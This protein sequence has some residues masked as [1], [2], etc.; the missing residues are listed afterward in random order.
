MTLGFQ[1]AD[2]GLDG[3][4]SS[5]FASDD[6]EDAALLSRDEDAA[7]VLR[8]MTAV[9][10]VDIVRLGGPLESALNGAVPQRPVKLLTTRS[11]AKT[12]K[13][14]PCF[15]SPSPRFDQMDGRSSA[16]GAINQSIQPNIMMKIICL[17]DWLARPIFGLCPA[18]GPPP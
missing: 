9:P 11:P 3:G 1:V 2:H 17:I 7:R 18:K 6:A 8:I 14:A 10:L 13:T 12:K 16:K 4:A 5:Q 15:H